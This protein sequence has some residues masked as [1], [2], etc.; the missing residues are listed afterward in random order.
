MRRCIAFV[1][2]LL[3][4]TMRPTAQAGEPVPLSNARE[5]KISLIR[6][7][8]R[9]QIKQLEELERKLVAAVTDEMPEDAA[10]DNAA[11]PMAGSGLIG[12]AKV[13]GR[14]SDILFHY[15]H[16]KVLNP[17]PVRSRIDGDFVLTLSGQLEVPRDM[18]VKVWHAGGG[19]SHDVNTLFVNDRK[20]SS[21]GDD[22]DK[23]AI[24]ELKLKKGSHI[25]RWELTGG[26]FR[27]NL[28]KF[29]DSDSDDMLPLSFAMDGLP[30]A[31]VREF[32]RIGSD[33]RGWPI[34]SDW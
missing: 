20:I 13:A 26:T 24:D 21:V 22:R 15:S 31:P 5:A 19:V 28:L 25:V 3:L 18:I 30:A 33:E 4:V 29:V 11:V 17:E 27:N 32:V 10:K 7:E 8:I 14:D 6:T 2:F 34:P 23:H 12:R 1:G 16:G 9:A